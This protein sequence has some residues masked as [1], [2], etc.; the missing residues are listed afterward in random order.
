[1]I[2]KDCCCQPVKNIKRMLMCKQEKKNRTC[3]FKSLSILVV[4]LDSSSANWTLSLIFDLKPNKTKTTC[5]QILVKNNASYKMHVVSMIPKIFIRNTTLIHTTLIIIKNLIVLQKS[6][7][8]R[9]TWEHK[10]MI[11]YNMVG[12]SICVLIITHLGL[13]L[14]SD[15]SNEGCAQTIIYSTCQRLLVSPCCHSIHIM[16]PK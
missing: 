7:P 15:L 10:W 6:N 3:G 14:L 11:A 9:M 16:M 5:F 12:W 13:P 4:R 8:K 1:M 2:K